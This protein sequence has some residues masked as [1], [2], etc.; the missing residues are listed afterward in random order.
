MKTKQTPYQQV[1]QLSRQASTLQGVA[2]LLG[3]DQETYMPK[4]AAEHRGEQRELLEGLIHQKKTSNTFARALSRL[5]HLETGALTA[6]NLTERSPTILALE[7]VAG[8]LARRTR[9]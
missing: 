9:C 3:W 5:I 1:A 7:S 4:A 6:E 8:P 2:S